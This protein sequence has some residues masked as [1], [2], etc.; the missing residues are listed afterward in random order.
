MMKFDQQV[1]KDFLTAE[2]PHLAMIRS[3]ESVYYQ[4]YLPL[5]GKVLDVGCGD[6]FFAWSIYRKQKL[7][8]GI[9]IENSLWTEAKARGNYQQVLAYD[10]KKIPFADNSFDTV[11]CNCVLEHVPQASE[12]LKEISR[13]VKKNGMFITTVVTSEFGDKLLGTRLAGPMYKNWL[14][15]KAVHVSNVSPLK[16]SQYFSEAN[17]KIVKKQIYFNSDL[18]MAWFD[19]THWWG[20]INL[21]TRTL[22]GKW[23][24]GPSKITNSWWQKIFEKI[25]QKAK[26]N[27]D[28]PYLFI[29]AKK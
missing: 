18:L 17:L 6:G 24:W 27:K 8:V 11:V 25:S 19:V 12:L 2:P 4:P 22:T 10:G 14:N 28:C 3:I 1:L 5:K 16:W 7:A 13:V 29:V 23:V 26:N 20:I 9:D 21:L 15:K